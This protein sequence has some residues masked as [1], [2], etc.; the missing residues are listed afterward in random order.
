MGGGIGGVDKLSGNEAA[1][2]LRRKLLRPGNGAF[3]ALCSLGQHQL[4]AVC[5]HQ[6]PP[7]HAHGLRHDDDDPVAPGCRHRG[8][9]NACIPGGGLNHHRAGAQQPPGFGIVK[10]SPGGTVLGAARRVEAFQLGQ[11]PGLQALLPLQTGQLQQGS[12]PDQLIHRCIDMAHTG[13]LSS[14]LCGSPA[15]AGRQC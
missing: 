7:F 8:Q 6:Q 13:L 1:G 3:H 9:T 11:N 2:D 12:P 15:P 10:H 5:L 14:H 4:R